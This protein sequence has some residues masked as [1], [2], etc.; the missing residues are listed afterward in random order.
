[1]RHNRW[2]AGFQAPVYPGGQSVSTGRPPRDTRRNLHRA[3]QEANESGRSRLAPPAG[4]RS[5][6]FITTEWFTVNVSSVPGL[7][8][9]W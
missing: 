6:Y 4:K 7:I 3:P 2:Q 8:T 9:T 1:L 5:P